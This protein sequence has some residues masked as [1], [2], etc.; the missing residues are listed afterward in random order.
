MQAFVPVAE[1]IDL[2]AGD[3]LEM[4]FS[5]ER[6]RLSVSKINVSTMTKGQE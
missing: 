1:P 4:R 2:T 3:R 6:Y 5:W